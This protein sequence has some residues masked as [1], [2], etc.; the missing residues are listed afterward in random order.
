MTFDEL[1]IA[2]PILRAI[3]DKGYTQP[4]PIQEQGIPLAL[5]GKDILGIAQTGTGKTAAFAVP[6]IQHLMEART[7]EAEEGLVTPKSGAAESVAALTQTDGEAQISGEAQAHGKPR[8]KDRRGRD[9]GKPHEKRVIRALILTPTRELAMQIDECFTDYGKYSGLRHCV[10]FGGVKQKPQTDKLE[11]GVDILVATPGRLLDLMGQKYVDLS[12]LTHF[13]LDEADRM[14]DMGFIVDIRR[15]LPR[16]PKERQTMFFS[17]TMPDDIVVLSRAI[18]TNPVRVEVTPAASTVETID[19]YIYFVEKPQRK[20]LLVSLLRKEAGKSVLI[21]ARTKHG[22][23]NIGKMLNRAGIPCDIIH[24]DKNQIQRQRALGDF[25]SGKIKIL[26]ATDIAARGIDI[27]QL[28]IVLNY[29]M[30]DLV[31]TY[32]HRI[33]RTG[34]AGNSGTALTF[35]SQDE[36]MMVRDIQQLSTRPV[37]MILHQ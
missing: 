3:T 35:C 30:P 28:D 19:Q 24:G 4:T 17:A 1:G 15:L 6:I 32:V 20:E 5:K 36:H 11:R 18:L 21:F 9:H 22:A 8:R 16:I 29:D 7:R 2:E 13:V 25:K 33:G 23:D 34:R 12:S 14:L 37:E 26:V 31:E 27:N 10:V